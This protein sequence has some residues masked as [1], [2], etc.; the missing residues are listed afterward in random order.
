MLVS[1]FQHGER[2]YTTS[3]EPVENFCHVAGTVERQRGGSLDV[4]ET[5]R[6]KV[7]GDR[8]AQLP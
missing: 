2:I 8:P 7:E 3:S 4:G 1:R 6:G 5:E